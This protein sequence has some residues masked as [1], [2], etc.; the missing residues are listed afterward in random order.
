[1]RQSLTSG[2]CIRQSL[3]SSCCVRQSLTSGCH[4]RHQVLN[5]KPV[6]NWENCLFAEHT[7]ELGELFVRRTYFGQFDERTIINLTEFLVRRSWFGQFDE[8]YFV[9]KWLI[10]RCKLRPELAAEAQ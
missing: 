7:S 3:T 6:L 4:A 9:L 2:C 10:M 1:M 8:L 5:W